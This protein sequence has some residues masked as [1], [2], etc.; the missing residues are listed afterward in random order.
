MKSV[1]DKAFWEARQ[2]LESVYYDSKP[3]AD[4]ILQG[5]LP[6]ENRLSFLEVGCVPGRFMVYF[7]RTFGYQVSGIDY[8]N[9]IQYMASTLS[10]HGIEKFEL[11]HCDFFQF[12]PVSKYDVVFSAGFVEHFSEPEVVFKKHYDLLKEG[13]FLVI[14][15]PNF[16]YAQ[17]L[18]RII[19]GLKYE[20][21]SHCLNTMYPS[22]WRT[23]A[24]K[25]NLLVLYCGYIHTFHFWFPPD[26][27][28]PLKPLI[29][30]AGRVIEKG[31][32]VLHLNQIPNRYFSPHILLVAKK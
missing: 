19:L 8:S 27:N 30:K 15:L 21:D 9:E 32:K 6:H 22:I 20:L 29:D 18:L 26:Y 25:E 28:S 17:K 5:L 2:K 4:Y 24:E 7:A 11:F 10:A 16:Q 12:S 13:G 14:S 31:L 3:P 1:V 23:L